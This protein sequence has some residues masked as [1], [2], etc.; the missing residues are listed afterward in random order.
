MA[1]RRMIS[2]VISISEKVNSLSL[3][4]R[5]L[6][7]WMI[8]HADD[9]GRLPGSPA[10]IRALVVPMGDETIKDVEAT[11]HD[12][13]T[14]ELI[15]WY[16]VEG[17]KYIE[18][19]SF[20]DH[21][22]GLHKRTKSKFPEPSEAKPPEKPEKPE[23]NDGTPGGDT[24]NI[25]NIPGN[26]GR[27]PLN[28]TELKGTELEEKGTGTELPAADENSAS[29]GQKPPPDFSFQNLYQIFSKHFVSDQTKLELA[30]EIFGDLYDTYGGEA[31][32]KAFRE[33]AKYE[34]YH[35]PYVESILMGKPKPEQK[36]GPPGKSTSVAV[37]PSAA[38][39]MQHLSEFERL[40]KAKQEMLRQRAEGQSA[41]GT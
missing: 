36:S 33:A 1:E 9:F 12:M 23:E 37:T 2:K 40:R 14:R 34:K 22:S 41:H 30:S 3:F 16:E 15:N 21:Q 10:K 38:D 20:D 18:I 25:Q 5:L 11:L 17:E 31:L 29:E 19:S 35:L 28:R 24:G 7:T 8:P 39:T 13:A 6:Y 27:F 26:S 4:G 32:Y